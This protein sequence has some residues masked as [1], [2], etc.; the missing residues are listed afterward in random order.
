MT[1]RWQG[2][3]LEYCDMAPGA[4]GLE[5]KATVHRSS[6][7][8]DHSCNFQHLESQA[9]RKIRAGR[10]HSTSNLLLQGYSGLAFVL[11]LPVLPF[12]HCLFPSFLQLTKLLSCI[13]TNLGVCFW[14]MILWFYEPASG[15]P[16]STDSTDYISPHW[17]HSV[18]S[19]SHAIPLQRHKKFSGLDCSWVPDQQV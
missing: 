11:P 12:Q 10:H 9:H 2:K 3:D 13:V 14:G 8:T 19:W 15:S 4:E 7:S 18:G 17:E 16:D 6:A 1:G 5:Y